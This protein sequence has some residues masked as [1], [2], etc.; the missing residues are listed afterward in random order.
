M[1]VQFT[2]LDDELHQEVKAVAALAGISAQS[3]VEAILTQKMGHEHALTPAIDKALR[4]Y[5]AGKAVKK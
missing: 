2:R 1:P 4:R 3:L 5:R